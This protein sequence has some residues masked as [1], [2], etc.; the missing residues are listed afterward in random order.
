MHSH[1]TQ[2]ES[3]QDQTPDSNERIDIVPVLCR[4]GENCGRSKKLTG[5]L[6]K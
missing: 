3:G 1:N 2:N 4:I 5:I 6:E